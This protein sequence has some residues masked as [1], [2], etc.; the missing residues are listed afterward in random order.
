MA[1]YGI[2]ISE[3]NGNIDLSKYKDQY[4]I[5]RAGYGVGHIDKKWE[6]N[7]KECE[8]LG[9]TYGA[10]WYSYAL[11]AKTAA[12]E[13]ECFCDALKGKNIRLGAWLDLED[14]DHYKAK[15]GWSPS[16]KIC[17]AIVNAFCAK[18]EAE[19]WYTGV[20]LS[21]SWLQ[22]LDT[23][24]TRY[25]RWIAHWGN[26]NGQR[27][28]DYK[29]YGSV[30]QYSSKPLDKDYFYKDDYPNPGYDPYDEDALK[31]LKTKNIDKI[32]KRAEQIKEMADR[33]YR[34][35]YGTGDE[36]RKKLGTNYKVVQDYINYLESKK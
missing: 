21:Y 31:I 35:E 36:R 4:V 8:K 17:S 16:K 6:R 11:D 33:V 15:R 19:G 27:H 29:K 22:Y 26:N 9:I 13:A 28:G 18:M 20:Y 3:H 34:N 1:H 7:V 5:I 24:T 14:A 30:H 12:Q 32:L 25:D 10:Y 2:D 23:S